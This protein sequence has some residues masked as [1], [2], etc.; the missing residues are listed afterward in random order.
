MLKGIIIEDD[1]R[2]CHTRIFLENKSHIICKNDYITNDLDFIIFPFA[3]DAD[4]K[5]YGHSFFS[6]LKK[7]VLIFSG[8]RSA[9]LTEK[10]REFGLE[11]IVMMEDKGIAEKN[12]VPTS[13]GVIAYLI[14][15]MI[16]TLEGSRILI[17]GYGNCGRD[18]A[19]R[20]KVL[21]ACVLALVRNEEKE[22][23]AAYD[24][25]TAVYLTDLH[26][27]DFDAIINTVPA[28]VLTDEM[29][30][31]RNGT[32]L[33]DISSKPYGFNIEKAKELNEKSALLSGIPGKYAVKTAGEILGEYIHDILEGGAS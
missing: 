26:K 6:G 20:L 17:I 29:L 14:T 33:I 12:A 5:V 7:D 1:R 31:D 10:C 24:G 9:Y 30:K 15:C 22:M 27:L 4:Q 21:G 2:Y 3:A 23:H 25:V 16:K 13:E 18:L 28:L 32:L 11:Y 19:K 8:V